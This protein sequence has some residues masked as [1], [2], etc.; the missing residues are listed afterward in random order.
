MSTV[1]TTH[2][3]ESADSIETPKDAAR[4]EAHWLVK[5]E[6]VRKKYCRDLRKSLW[7]ALGDVIGAL[8]LRSNDTNKLRDA[9]F[10]AVN[11]VS[12]TVNRGDSL[13][14]LGRN[15]AG[16]STLLKMI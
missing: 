11:D 12:F 7:Y 16:K 2:R 10:W 1:E 4:F 6:N 9:E 3:D 14:L 5:V 8:T 13:G 15:G